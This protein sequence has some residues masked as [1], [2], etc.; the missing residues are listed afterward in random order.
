MEKIS[1][2][3]LDLEEVTEDELFME[4]AAGFGNNQDD[5]SD[6]NAAKYTVGWYC[7]GSSVAV[8]LSS[9][10]SASDPSNTYTELGCC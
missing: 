1:K 9:L 8:S 4:L 10:I 5:G 6:Q 3:D 7:L 2:F